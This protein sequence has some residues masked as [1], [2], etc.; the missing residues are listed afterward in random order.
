VATTTLTGTTG[1]D[2]LNAPGSVTTLVAGYKGND[3]I[4]LQ[5]AA[6]IAQ[7]GQGNDS[8]TIAGVSSLNTVFGGL[9]NDSLYLKTAVESLNANISL[10]AGDDQFDNSRVQVVGGI[11]GG[12]AGADTIQLL[13]GVLNAEVG[14]GADNDSIAFS[15]IATNATVTGGKGADTISVGAGTWSLSTVQ[16]GDGHDRLLLSAAAG[17]STFVAGGGKG[18]DSIRIGN[19]TFATVAGGGLDDT[20]RFT[21]ADFG[22]GKVYG[23]AIGTTTA[24][25]GT[26]GAADGADLFIATKTVFG[27]ATTIYGGGGSDTVQLNSTA[28]TALLLIDGGNGNDLIGQTTTDFVKALTGSQIL[29]GAGADT[30]KFERGANAFTVDGGA[31]ADSI[32]IGTAT[33]TFNVKGGAD[34]DT[35]TLDGGGEGLFNALGTIDGGAGVDSIILNDTKGSAGV[36]KAYTLLTGVV[37][38]IKYGSGDIIALTSA[39]TWLASSFTAVNIGKALPSVAIITTMTAIDSK[40][41]ASQLYGNTITGN[42]SVFDTDGNAGTSGDL[43]IGINNGAAQTK[44]ALIRII[45]GDELIT[46]TKVGKQSSSLVNITFA[47]LGVHGY[48]LTLG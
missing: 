23:D 26:G 11:I 4:T 12:N 6:D 1:N 20:I 47:K 44:L 39:T 41:L 16:G 42:I 19:T 35:I 10:G 7:A 21:N 27:T 3:T 5:K 31:G 18:S 29:G 48:N 36:E 25:T 24:G 13:N 45:G 33:D 37:A 2:I 40:L 28:T 15:G 43:I 8:I 22:G 14:S 32:Y 34:N 46:T 9:G 30:I 17:S 38:T